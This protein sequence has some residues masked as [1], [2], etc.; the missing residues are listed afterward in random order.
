[1]H[2]TT[3]S[4]LAVM[5]GP[6][7]CKLCVGRKVDEIIQDP[8]D[9]FYGFFGGGDASLLHFAKDSKHAESCFFVG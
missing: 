1:M 7:V 2:W 6:I 3:W 5:S 4:L 9:Y 8:I